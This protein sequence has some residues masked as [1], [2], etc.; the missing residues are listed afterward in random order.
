MKNKTLILSLLIISLSL[1]ACAPAARDQEIIET[2]TTVPTQKPLEAPTESEKDVTETENIDPLE[3]STWILTGILLNGEMT[4]TEID[5][6][7]TVEFKDGQ[8]GGSAG[9]NRYFSSYQVDGTSLVLDMIGS[10]RM[11]CDEAH[12]QRESEFLQ[13]LENVTGYRLLDIDKT[14]EL[15]D[16]NGEPLISL[17]APLESAFPTELL[18]TW[19][20]A[21]YQDMAELN[22]ISVPDPSKYTLEF[23]A[24]G[25]VQIKA[26]CNNAGGGTT[27]SNGEL[28][29]GPMMTTL[30]ECGPDS[31]YSEYL[32]DLG[33]V[34][35]Y[36]IEG[37]TLYLN[38][39]MDAGTMVF[40]R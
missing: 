16:K 20:W 21:A 2:A 38:L 19:R 40:E 39:K 9:C 22:D 8:I 36:I 12:N 14:L 32:A 3:G 34:V 10:T 33:G 1:T 18:G 7:I 11:A 6:E 31:L 25:T 37:D 29:F 27:A 5:Q 4:T 30:A 26:D 23:L 17:Q 28:A 35:G 24:D 13:A 15:F